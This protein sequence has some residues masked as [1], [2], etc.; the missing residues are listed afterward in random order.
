MG[1]VVLNPPPEAS[2]TGA[3]AVRP[4]WGQARESTLLAYPGDG[5]AEGSCAKAGVHPQV[6]QRT[7]KRPTSDSSGVQ[8]E[9]NAH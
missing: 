9:I 5:R 3:T 6:N 4:L 7:F 2:L 8:G 1:L